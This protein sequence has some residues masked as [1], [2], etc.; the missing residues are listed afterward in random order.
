MNVNW[1]R[2]LAFL[3]VLSAFAAIAWANLAHAEEWDPITD[4]H[5]YDVRFSRLE[6]GTLP[7]SCK[8]FSK[9][10][11]VRLK[12]KAP[13]ALVPWNA[14]ENPHVYAP[15]LESITKIIWNSADLYD[16]GKVNTVLQVGLK[17]GEWQVQIRSSRMGRDGILK[18]KWSDAFG[19]FLQEMDAPFDRPVEVIIDF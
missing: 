2:M 14:Q 4:V 18:S 3:L 19:F 8:T 13:A 17:P 1:K 11:S 16:Q 10:D 9:T 15:E 7:E 5:S 6:P 12:W